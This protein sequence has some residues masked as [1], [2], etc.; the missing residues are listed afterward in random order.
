MLCKL[1][2]LI[3]ILTKI[4]YYLA[5]IMHYHA[6]KQRKNSSK[7]KQQKQKKAITGL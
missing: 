3:C 7:N 5:T 2:F 1:L 6:P 4:R